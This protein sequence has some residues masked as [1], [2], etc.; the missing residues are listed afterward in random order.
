MTVNYGKKIK[1]G[2][3]SYSLTVQNSFK[4]YSEQ[5]VHLS[6]RNLR[7]II[8]FSKNI[9]CLFLILIF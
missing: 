2:I 7:E 8:I 1:F 3:S 5:F 9:T 6:N 4:K